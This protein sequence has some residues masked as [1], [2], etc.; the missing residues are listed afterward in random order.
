MSRNAVDIMWSNFLFIEL[1]VNIY[2]DL[3]KKFSHSWG[4]A[5]LSS[6]ENVTAFGRAM[7]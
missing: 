1:R 2:E 5:L 6:F 3:M 7:A 4:L